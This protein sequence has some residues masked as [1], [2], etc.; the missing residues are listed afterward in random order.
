MKAL[1]LTVGVLSDALP[2]VPVRAGAARQEDALPFVVVSQSDADRR[3]LG[4]LVGATVTILCVALTLTA[5]A[6]VFEQVRQSFDRLQNVD[7][8]GVRLR[9]AFLQGES[10][11]YFPP[12]E[13]ENVGWHAINST[14]KVWF[15]E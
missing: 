9:G 12:E 1:A 8:G 6:E 5:A 2:G 7:V 4:D 3:Q 14:F 13:G 15:R 10:S 11:Q